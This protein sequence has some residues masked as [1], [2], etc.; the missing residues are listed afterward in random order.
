M[1][2]ID[3]SAIIAILQDEPECKAFIKVI[4]RA[5][6]C[7][8]SAVSFVEAS[9][10]IEARYGY[11]GLRDF[12]LFVLKASIDVATVDAEQASLAREAFSKFGKGRHVANLNFGDCFSYALAKSLGASLLFKGND[13]TKT[14]IEPAIIDG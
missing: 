10:V 12:D 5:T 7:H 6:A 8:I 3:T 13:F 1:I 2:V 11:N 4:E 9:M 14:D